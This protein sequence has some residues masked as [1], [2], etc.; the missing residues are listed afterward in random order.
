MFSLTC[1]ERFLWIFVNDFR[2]SGLGNHLQCIE[3]LR[4]Y[5]Q[6]VNLKMIISLIAKFLYNDAL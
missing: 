6:N 2:Q 1:P 3:F 4:L 5:V